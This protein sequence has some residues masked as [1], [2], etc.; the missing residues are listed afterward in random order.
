MMKK[1]IKKD[2]EKVD[3]YDFLIAWS[4]GMNDYEISQKLG[5]SLETVQEV[6]KDL[7]EEDNS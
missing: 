6:M 7:M 1:E 4:T 3:R 2:K 5:V